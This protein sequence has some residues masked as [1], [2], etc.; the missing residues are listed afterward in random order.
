MRSAS[1]ALYCNNILYAIC[2]SCYVGMFDVS[3]KSIIVVICRGLG[4][5]S[6]LEL[7]M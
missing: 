1:I 6:N 2:N 3:G 5:G 4:L 7:N